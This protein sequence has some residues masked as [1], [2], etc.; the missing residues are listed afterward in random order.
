[1]PA[2]YRPLRRPIH[3]FLS[4]EDG[5]MTVFALFL[6]VV[7]I[8]VSALAVDFT[9]FETHRARIQSTIDR[10]VLAAADL[11]NRADECA[12]VRDYAQKDGIGDY[13]ADCDAIE[14]VSGTVVTS[15]EVRVEA[16]M[17]MPTMLLP[18]LGIDQLS[19]P[20]STSAR[21]AVSNI[22]IVLVLD[23]SG[24]M[25]Q[26]G[27]QKLANLKTAANQFVSTVLSDDPDHRVSVAIVPFNGQV[28][29]GP[30][31]GPKYTLTEVAQPTYGRSSY[32]HLFCVDLPPSAYAGMTLSRTAA[33]PATAMAD[34]FSST[35]GVWDSDGD[36]LADGSNDTYYAWN[37]TYDGIAYATPR[38]ANMWCPSVNDSGT[39]TSGNVVRLPSHSITTLQSNVNSMVGIG[40]TSINAGMRWGLTLLDPANQALYTQF[41]AAGQMPSQFAGRPFPFRTANTVKIIVV[42]TD[43][44]NFAEERV[45][46]P[47]R[48]GSSGTIFRSSI[49]NNY[50][51]FHGARVDRT[52]STT[53][54]NSRP[55][56]VPHL[57][58][59][60]SRPWAG[61][62][63]STDM[64]YA[65]GTRRRFDVNG[66]GVCNS[67]DDGRGSLTAS[68]ACWLST[69]TSEQSWPT[70]WNNQRMS[71]V[72]YQLYGRAL[73]DSNGTSYST[74]TAAYNAQIGLFRLRTDVDDM[75][76]QLQTMCDLAIANGVVIYGIAFEA[77]TL[78]RQAISSCVGANTANYFDAAGLNI[79]DAFAA[80]AAQVNALRLVQ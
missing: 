69:R 29:L 12:T 50:S 38:S 78:G 26:N 68:Q 57:S 65:E 40:A 4:R 22:E 75:N 47:F 62:S 55:F 6:F 48:A 21:E 15:R 31:V 52:T 64:P 25:V 20:A 19:V 27:S 46:S 5:S 23:V 18:F 39:S 76:T 49:D 45:R 61:T 3:R 17:T 10:A 71:W 1:M 73:M 63:P 80:I 7:M 30:V 41:I 53:R 59:W 9:R 8:M 34:T 35:V 44:S 43:G 79:K 74:R 67:S 2:P 11:D 42:L 32:S 16:A 24:S 28:N 54:A 70:I 36:G 66:D 51:I 77:P 37:F 72:A 56:W 33:M 13:I 60:H 58:E 14:A